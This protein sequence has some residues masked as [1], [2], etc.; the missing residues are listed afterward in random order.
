MKSRGLLIGAY[1]LTMYTT[2][3][4]ILSLVFYVLENPDDETSAA[5]FRDASEG[6][7]A[8]ASL[9][10]RSNAADRCMTTLNVSFLNTGQA[11]LLIQRTR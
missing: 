6:K 4:A 10:R 1:W 7:D 5:C 11:D 9:A 3:F 8:L 2:F